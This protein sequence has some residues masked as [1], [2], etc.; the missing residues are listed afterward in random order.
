MRARQVEDVALRNAEGREE[1]ARR[2]EQLVGELTAARTEALNANGEVLAARADLSA[3]LTRASRQTT[4]L[5]KFE[6]ESAS[7]DDE[8]RVAQA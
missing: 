3:A 5:G 7:F 2:S 6:G 4:L 1:F 8:L